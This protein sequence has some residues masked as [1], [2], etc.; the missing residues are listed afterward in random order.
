MILHTTLPREL[1]FQELDQSHEEKQMYLYHGIPII[2]QPT[3]DNQLRISQ[4]LSTNPNHFL[5]PHCIPGRTVSLFPSNL[6]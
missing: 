4:V 5:H 3:E 2:A 6:L 1:I